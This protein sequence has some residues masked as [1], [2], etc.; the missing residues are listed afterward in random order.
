VG[1]EV[2]AADDEY[3]AVLKP[4]SLGCDTPIAFYARG[5]MRPMTDVVVLLPGITGSVLREDRGRDLWAPTART[6]TRALN[7]PGVEHRRP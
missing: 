4:F 7:H 3:L 5:I 2:R 1:V 6:A